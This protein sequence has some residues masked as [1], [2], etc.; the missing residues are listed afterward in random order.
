VLP[1]NCDKTNVLLNLMEGP[2]GD[3]RTYMYSKSLHNRNIDT[4]Q[5]YK[6]RSRKSIDYFTFSNNS[7]FTER[8]VSEFHL[9]LWWCG[10]HKRVLCNGTTRRRW[11]L[12]FLLDIAKIPKHFIRDNANLLILFKQDSTNLKTHVQRSREYRCVLWGFLRFMS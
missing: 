3:S 7:D 2:H 12:L 8:G 10:K 5:I 4:W 6:H 11:L 1:S 9:Y